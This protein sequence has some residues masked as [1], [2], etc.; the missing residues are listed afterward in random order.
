MR[1]GIVSD[2]HDKADTMAAAVKLLRD[3]GAEFFVHCGDVGSPRVLDHLA[4]L[5][6]CFVFGN[7][8][9]DRAGLR[10]YAEDIEVACHNT[11][12]DLTLDG[13]RIAV[14]HGDDGKLKQ[15]LLAEQQHDYLFQGHTHVREDTRVGKIRLINPGALH[16][17]N[18]KTAALLDTS[19]D[20]L[21]FLIVG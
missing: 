6:G 3:C 10:R 7:C 4:G 13:K 15:R 17:A 8:D 5:A 16:R 11:F 9:W 20:K 18:P 14:I 1:I 19:S 12:G 21:E 2:T